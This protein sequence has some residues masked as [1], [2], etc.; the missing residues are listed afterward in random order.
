VQ[1]N[2]VKGEWTCNCGQMSI[3][4]CQYHLKYWRE[5]EQDRWCLG[6]IS[7]TVQRVWSVQCMRVQCKGVLVYAK[8]A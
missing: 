1:L 8:T 4:K 7:V 6:V 5:L 2:C 3:G